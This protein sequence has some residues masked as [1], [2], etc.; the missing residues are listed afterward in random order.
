MP[1]LGSLPAT[2]DQRKSEQ[3]LYKNKQAMQWNGVVSYK[4]L[5]KWPYKRQCNVKEYFIGRL[6]LTWAWNARKGDKVVHVSVHKQ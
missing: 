1:A 5:I 2:Y 6:D 3:W 4:E